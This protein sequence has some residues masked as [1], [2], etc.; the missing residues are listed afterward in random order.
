MQVEMSRSMFNN[1]GDQ[2]R[3]FR[4]NAALADS[5]VYR[6]S[7]S[8]VALCHTGATE[9]YVCE[10][11]DSVLPA[12]TEPLTGTSAIDTTPTSIAGTALTPPATPN[13]ARIPD[14]LQSGSV[15]KPYH[16]SVSGTLYRG[17]VQ[18]AQAAQISPAIHDIGAVPNADPRPAMPDWLSGLGLAI[19]AACGIAF[20]VFWRRRKQAVASDPVET[21]DEFA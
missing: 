16:N 4:P 3:L 9:A 20:F 1:A 6:Q 13:R 21:V 12:S 17:L 14:S 19:V 15:A 10:E 5:V 8:G 11:H 2:V 18:P 7:T